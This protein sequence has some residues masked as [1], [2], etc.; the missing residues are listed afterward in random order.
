M[1]AMKLGIEGSLMLIEASDKIKSILKRD[2]ERAESV[3]RVFS[4]R[5]LPPRSS[6]IIYEQYKLWVEHK[7]VIPGDGS[8]TVTVA[9]ISTAVCEVRG[10]KKTSSSVRLLPKTYDGN[11]DIEVWHRGDVLKETSHLYTTTGGVLVL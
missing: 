11:P 2:I 10:D 5:E 1:R 6:T 3:A 7:E 8:K 9:G 4:A